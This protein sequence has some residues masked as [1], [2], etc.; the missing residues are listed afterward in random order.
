MII[1][2][3]INL[4]SYQEDAISFVLDNISN[5]DVLLAAA[6]NAGKTF[7]SS[8]IIKQL[9]SDGSRVLCSVHGTNVLK[10]QFYDSI[11]GIVGYESVSIYDTSDFSL[12]DPS[13]PVQV[14]IY[15]NTKQMEECVEQYGM[16][17]YL[18]VDEAHKFYDGTASMETICDE[19]VSGNHLLLTGSPAIFKEKVESGEIAGTYISAGLIESVHSGQYD[20]DIRLDVVSNDVH[21][22][23]DDYNVN[24]EVCK[25]SEKKLTHNDAVLESLLVGDFGKTIIFVK[26]T[27]QADDIQKYLRNR[28][29]TNFVSHS[30]SDKDSNNIDTFKR[31]YT[32]VDN[33]VLIVVD[34][35]T[36]GFDDPNVSIIDMTY[37]KNIDALYQ[38]YSRAIRK[39]TDATDKRYIK[40]VPNNGNSAEVYIHIMTAVLM[41]LKQ[42]HYENFNG[43]N[44]SIPTLKQIVKAPKSGVGVVKSYVEKPKL[45]TS[46]ISDNTIIIKSEDNPVSVKDLV[47]NDNFIVNVK[48]DGEVYEIKKE[49]YNDWVDRLDGVDYVISVEKSNDKVDDCLLM[50]TRLYSNNFFDINDELYGIITRYATSNLR[51]VLNQINGDDYY[52]DKEGY[53]KLFRDEDIT[54]SGIWSKEY[55][56]LCKRDG[57]KYHSTPYVLFGQTAKDFFDECF[58]KQDFFNDKEG[59]YKLFREENITS[60]VWIKNY[61][62]FRE[63][64]EIKYHCAPWCLFGQSQKEF[65]DECYPCN[66]FYVDKE[67]YFELF[68]KD[69]ITNCGDWNKKNK[70]LSKRDGVKYHSNPWRLFNQTPKIFF[71][72][73]YPD[74][75]DFFNNKEGY[76]E[77]FRNENITHSGV[78]SKN[79]KRLGERDGVK[80]HSSPHRL[81]G[82]TQKEFFAECYSDKQEIFN[83]KEGYFEL[84]RKENITG[85]S[86]WS[87]KYK[88]LSERDGVNYHSTPCVL[89]GQTI[90]EFFDECFDKQEIFNDKEGYFELFRKENITGSSVWSK[91]YKS[92]SERDVIK[93]HSHPWDLFRQTV[94]EFFLECY[95]NKEEA[96][97]DKEGYYKLIRKEENIT[98]GDIWVKRYK[99]LSKRDGMIYRCEP[100]TLFNQSAKEFFIEYRE[101]LENNPKKEREYHPAYLGEFSEMNKKWNTSNSKTTH[102]R[103]KED[104]KEWFKYHKLYSDA[105]KNWS[106]IP[107]KVIA[108]IIKARPEW[109]VGDFGC[110]EN[111]LSKEIP[112]K[113]LSFDHV[114]IED[115]VTVCDLTNIPLEDSK[116]DVIVFSL[117]LMGTNY[118]EY[119]KEAY[120]TLKPMGMV[121]IAEPSNRWEDRDDELKSMLIEEG[122]NIS[123]DVTHTDKFIYVTA[124]KL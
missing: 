51:D 54:N 2:Q 69:N 31:N 58:D 118:K 101:W 43:K 123:G 120:R 76:F 104:N 3:P 81:F 46:D 8:F 93:Y 10:K 35:A 85:S 20:R 61:K 57:V 79:F 112:N 91:K 65:D 60:S 32:G 7:M 94:K 50:E 37:S 18:V 11:S 124:I 95:P 56:I 34:R 14:M 103:L 25:K 63:R 106:E 82:Q 66:N 45:E 33:V 84:F 108:N 110:G 13:K 24:G 96:F 68:R 6:P 71:L 44:F 30:K 114:A 97:K 52:A 121:I 122:F 62:R 22:T 15:Q 48:I 72:G 59:Y 1:S 80:Y 98:S 87:K 116:L 73:C 100:W 19:Y 113:V 53:F 99:E 77:L 12:Y 117:S 26:R 39:R 92:L 88:S 86:V 36:E 90:K 109:V 49:D 70:G 107:Y 105:R 5:T 67:G 17:D 111:L 40:V 102:D 28:K 115:A 75:Q 74:K 23:I 83:D 119:F 9:I 27:Q 78:W 55:K 41:L 47:D 64:D 4:Y 38:R 16:F 89:F 42:E 21:L 29:I